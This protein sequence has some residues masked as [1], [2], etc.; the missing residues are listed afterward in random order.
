MVSSRITQQD[1]ATALGVSAQTVSMALRDHRKVSAATRAKV[2]AKAAELGYVPDPALTALAEYRSRKR[3][4]ALRWSHVALVHNWPSERAWREDSFYRW[5][6]AELVRVLS[7]RGM[8][9]EEHW[10]GPAGEKAD[11]VFRM[12]WSRGITGVFVAPPAL[13][14]DPPRI[15][16]H[17]ARFQWVTFGPE[18]LYADL[19][20]VQFDFYGNL[21]LAWKKLREQGRQRIGLVYHENQGWRTGHAWR[22]AY[23]VETLLSGQDVHNVQPL[24]LDGVSGTSAVARYGEWMKRGKYDAVISSVRDVLDWNRGLKHPPDIAMFNVRSP[25]EQGIDLNLPQMAET[26]VELLLLEMRQ[27]LIHQKSLPFR[28]HIPG[29]WVSCAG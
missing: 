10:L 14:R 12:L 2:K 20:T 8:T 22:A 5:W 18:D 28:V 1:V 16:L 24:M 3:T 29:T 6:R 15:E 9:L 26:A 4:P 27:T 17:R 11:A 13:T 19:H 7:E 21:R 25:G 23:H